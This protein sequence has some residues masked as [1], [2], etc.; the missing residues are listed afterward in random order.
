LQDGSYLRLKNIQIGYTLPKN[1]ADKISVGSMRVYVGAQNLLTFTK[2]E[3]LDP[4]IG[5]SQ[6]NGSGNG[7]PTS[8]GIDRATYPQSKTIMLGINLNF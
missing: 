5:G 2:Y 4:E 6:A 1:I 8:F 7:D 3:G